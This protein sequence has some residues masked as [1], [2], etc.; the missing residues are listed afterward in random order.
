MYHGWWS[1]GDY[2][3][4]N[5][6][7]YRYTNSRTKDVLKQ[8]IDTVVTPLGPSLLQ[9]P[10]MPSDIAFL[11]SFSSEMFAQVGEFGWGWGWANDAYQIL[12]YAH[13][14]P[15]VVYEESIQKGALDGVKILVAVKCPVLTKSVAEKILD[16]QKNGGIIIGDENLAPG[17]TPDIILKSCS[18][19]KSPHENKAVLQAK[20]QELMSELRTVYSPYA[21]C[22]NPDVILR[23][24]RYGNCD[25]LFVINDKRTY[26][27]YVGQFGKV[28]EKGLPLKATVKL[29]RKDKVYVYD[30]VKHQLVKTQT[31]NGR[32]NLPVQLE[33]GV[34]KLFMISKQPVQ[35]VALDV[36]QKVER[37]NKLPI[38]VRIIDHAGKAVNGIIPLELSIIDSKGEKVEFSGYYGVKNGEME[39]I[40]DIAG[41]DRPGAWQVIAK[42]LASN[43][44]ASKEFTVY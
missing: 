10:E 18:R 19:T 28:M 2:Y 7:K 23:T 29:N 1:L 24:R 43:K 3:P 27:N 42:E 30:L 38:T 8:L 40:L 26:G 17:I 25:Y 15:K 39:V 36:P 44:S 22:S 12:R 35:N 11:Q 31:L 32:L 5:R 4:N 13:L 14:Q 16:F 41:N 21:D 33:A 34:G 20:A 37:N 9:I 6:W